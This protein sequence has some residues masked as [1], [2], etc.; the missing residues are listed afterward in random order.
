MNCK[1][2]PIVNSGCIV[3]FNKLF[4]KKEP[5]VDTISTIGSLFFSRKALNVEGFFFLQWTHLLKWVWKTESFLKNANFSSVYRYFVPPSLNFWKKGFNILHVLYFVCKLRF[6]K[7]TFWVEKC[8]ENFCIYN[9]IM[10]DK[11]HNC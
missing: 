1:I 5:M 11:T 3:L 6:L 7:C 4:A 10:L 2:A 8:I 9:I